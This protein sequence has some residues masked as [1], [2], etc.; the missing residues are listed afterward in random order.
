[1]SRRGKDCRAL[2]SV[3]WKTRRDDRLVST[4]HSTRYP[5]Q[6]F[7]TKPGGV[8]RPWNRRPGPGRTPPSAG[9][10]HL[11][12]G[13]SRLRPG[14]PGLG[15]AGRVE[16]AEDLAV[17]GIPDE[18]DAVGSTGR[19]PVAVVRDGDAEHEVVRAIEGAGDLPVLAAV[20]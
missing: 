9:L 15:R 5:E 18:Q 14:C 11:P 7:A 19:D 10:R 17:L 2:F 20:G 16:L 3:R 13:S 1:M 4:G 8:P 6:R 12:G